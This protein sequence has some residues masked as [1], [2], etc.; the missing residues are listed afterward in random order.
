M[1]NSHQNTHTP[2]QILLVDRLG[3]DG[4]EDKDKIEDYLASVGEAEEDRGKIEDYV[5]SVGE[6]VKTVL[7]DKPFLSSITTLLDREEHGEDM[8]PPAK[9]QRHGD[10]VGGT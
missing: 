2:L 9:R 5:A 1:D 4:E 6:A 8:S 7:E 10:E 3:V